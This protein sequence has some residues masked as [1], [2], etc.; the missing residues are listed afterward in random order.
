[1]DRDKE[2]D[3]HADAY[4]DLVAESVRA[5]GEG[6][7]YFADYKRRV[8]ARLAG[9]ETHPVLDYGCGVGELTRFLAETF[10]VVHGVDPSPRSV[11]IARARVPSAWFTGDPRELAPGRYGTI[12]LAN[13]LHHVPPAGR[14]RLLGSLIPLLRRGG[15]LVVFENNPLNPLTRRAMRSCVFDEDAVW[16]YPWEVRRRLRAAGLRGVRLDYIVFFP[17]ALARLRPLEPRLARV[18][19]GAQV[20]AW[21]HSP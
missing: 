14:E 15:R 17:R 4:G 18:A 20:V 19:I 10:P 1:M 3:A 2:F 8:L 6:T 16:L 11:A 12:V 13:V 7:A 21:G 5:S 9:A